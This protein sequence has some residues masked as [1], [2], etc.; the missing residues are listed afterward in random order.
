MQIAYAHLKLVN[1]R[2]LFQYFIGDKMATTVSWT[3]IDLALEPPCVG[4]DDAA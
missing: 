1:L 2:H 4:S 3:E